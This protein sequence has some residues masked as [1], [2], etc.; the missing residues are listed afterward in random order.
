MIVPPALHFQSAV[1]NFAPDA[2]GCAQDQDLA[3]D[4]KPLEGAADVGRLNLYLSVENDSPGDFQRGATVHFGFDCALD[5][6]PFAGLDSA[7]ERDAAP[8]DKAFALAVSAGRNPAD[9][10]GAGLVTRCSGWARSTG[11]CVGGAA[12]GASLGG[13]SSGSSAS[14]SSRR[15][16][17]NPSCGSIF[18]FSRSNIFDPV[19]RGCAAGYFGG[20]GDVDKLAVG[21]PGRRIEAWNVPVAAEI[22]DP[23][24][25]ERKTVGGCLFLA[26]EDCGNHR[27]GMEL[28][29][30][31][32]QIDGVLAGADRRPAFARTI[33]F[34]LG[35]QAGPPAQGDPDMI[36]SARCKDHGLFE[37][38]A[39]QLLLVARR[40][41]G[42]VPSALEIVAESQDCIAICGIELAWPITLTALQ[43]DLR[44]LERV[45]TLFPFPLQ[46]TRLHTPPMAG[47]AVCRQSPE[48]GAGWFSCLTSAPM[49]QAEVF[50]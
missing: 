47:P 40:G 18:A 50:S 13:T 15:R 3:G 34:D 10:S 27:I 1:G 19:V 11:A 36:F 37:H 8:D 20:L 35:Q 45:Q 9:R 39:Q 41:R 44:F 5:D 26:I 32:N 2:A 21:R 14:A 4:K 16:C 31:A 24:A 49:G 22:A 46:A 23:V 6:E 33:E 7:A 25:V 48:V 43:R 38:R 29:E 30:A 42:S 17:P 28:S 12:E